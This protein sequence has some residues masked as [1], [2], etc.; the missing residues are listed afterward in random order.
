[1]ANDADR[2]L[3]FGLL[4]LQNGLIDQG[5][6]VAA[7]QAWTRDRVRPLADYLVGRGDLEAADCSAIEAL[8]ARH[9]KKHGDDVE[10]SLAAVTAGRSTIE[11]L[12]GLGDPQVEVSLTRV[13]P[14]SGPDSDA[15]RTRTYA[16]GTA[17]S[18]GQRY[19]VLR[20]HARGGLGAVFVALDEELHREVALKEMLDHHAD[21]PVSRQRFL[22][23]AEITGGL[24]HPGI[25]PVY[26]LGTSA[27]G[28]PFYAMR[29]VKGDNLKE[30]AEQFHADQALKADPGRRSLELRKLLRRFLDVCNAIEYAHSR[31]V[32]HRDIKP[33]NVIVGKHG[34]TLVVDWGLAKPLGKVEPGGEASERPLTPSSGSGSAETLPGSALGTPAYMSPEQ[35][36]GDL[37]HL[38]PQSDVYSLGATLYCLLTGKPP[39]EG[40]VGDVLRAVQ[41]GAVA[42]PRNLDPTVDA[43]LEAVCLKSMA[44][45]PG[46]RY[47]SPKALA[48]DVERWMADEPVSAWREPLSRRA[49]RWARRNRTA[50]TAAA[51]LLLTAV[52]ALSVSTVL[53]NRERV[54]A[55]ANFRQARAA[56]D[57]YFTKVS[58]STL[59]DVPGLQPLRR[60]LLDSARRYYEGF[61]RQRGDDPG[62]RAEAA[63]TYYRLAIL[64]SLIGSKEVAVAL[65]GRAQGHYEGLV[66]AHPGVTR[67]Q[68]DL[69]ICC[70][71]LANLYRVTGRA[72]EALG[73][74]RRALEIRERMALAHPR[75]AR[76][77]N[78]LAKSHVNLGNLDI[79]AG[80]VA[81]AVEHFQKARAIGEQV[82]ADPEPDLD[83]PTD[84]GQRYNSR[85]ALLN[86]L[87]RSYLNM[88]YA[89]FAAGE[90]AESL[91]S[92][93]QALAVAVQLVRDHPADREQ[94]ALLANCQTDIAVL[95]DHIGRP[96]ASLRAYQEGRAVLEAMVEANPT[97]WDHRKHL[98]ETYKNLARILLTRGRPAE[99][100]DFAEK[101]RAILEALVA[102]N[103]TITWFRWVLAEDDRS[104][105]ALFLRLG[106]MDD[107]QRHL[108]TC[109]ATLEKLVSDDPSTLEFRS[110]LAA[111][112]DELGYVL[113]RTGRPE[114]ALRSYE[115]ARAIRE[116]LVAGSPSVTNLQQGLATT[117]NNLG[118]LKR[119]VA[120]PDEAVGYYRKAHAILEKLAGDHPDV[121]YYQTT[122]GYTC[123]GL[124]RISAQVGRPGEALK[125]LDQAAAL[126]QRYADTHP[127]A[128]YDLACDLALGV[129]LVGQAGDGQDAAAEARR[130]E[131]AD[132]AMEALRRAIAQGY[133]FPAI[134]SRDADLDPL[135]LRPDFQLLIMDLAM[136][137]DPFAR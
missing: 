126:D 111:A 7:F 99:A 105:A 135:R 49:R 100:L 90:T 81:E 43:A 116:V 115:A 47:P 87:A 13:G 134:I 28:R 95:L 39:F 92:R 17:T 52:V 2:H 91:R 25:V 133:T 8:V 56:V 110:S 102:E 97:I 84:L 125:W 50:V 55:E 64:T 65:F 24:E 109:R 74:H 98:A 1:M 30:A 42:L 124:A 136:P 19:R 22:L 58:E 123:R 122:L 106:R 85:A 68:C 82:A 21:D 4:A 63:A 46:E 67:F 121:Y 71:D 26:G 45:K 38:G 54:R 70:N 32:L 18:D 132:R 86:D 62:V 119:D 44:R 5:Q 120:R 61:L 80:R 9:L 104:L 37:E 131:R 112:Q 93:E 114:E 40:E 137:A 69:A 73:T 88:S 12:A 96:E 35:A 20:P 51:A 41:R 89:Q 76:F 66:R 130:L 117:Y 113:A 10:Q 107:A 59:L 101:G 48:D 33:G 14:E 23:E 128:R 83:F 77:Q 3:L 31:G 129:P 127:L 60:E 79:N 15:E 16:I 27:G 103:P 36:A 94:Q 75:G 29:F 72:I 6:L 11:S 108:E 78:E 57:E 34:E 118:R 53:I